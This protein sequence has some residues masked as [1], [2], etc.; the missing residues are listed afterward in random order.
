M[1]AI[2]RAI[3]IV[4]LAL[5]LLAPLGAAA[6]TEIFDQGSQPVSVVLVPAGFET[7]GDAASD[8]VSVVL[9]PSGFETNGDAVSDPVSVVL[10][11]SGF[12][13]N[14]EAVSDPV[15][16]VLTPT[17][18]ETNGEAMSEP[19][20][21]LLTDGSVTFTLTMQFSPVGSGSLCFSPYH[22]GTYSYGEEVRVDAVPWP[23]YTFSH[24]SGDATGTENPFWVIVNSDLA[25]TANFTVETSPPSSSI[26]A[27]VAG[28]VVSGSNLA[29]TGTATDGDMSQAGVLKVEVS[30]NGGITWCKASDTSG[31]TWAS[32]RYDWAIG[33][34]NKRTLISRATD[35]AGNVETP[36]EG[37]SVTVAATGTPE[38]QHYNWN[39]VLSNGCAGCHACPNKFLPTDFGQKNAFCYSCHNAAGV[40]HDKGLYSGNHSVMVNATTGGSRMPTY[41]NISASER[42]NQ[43]FANLNDG[44]VVCITCHNAMGKSE[45]MGRTWEY[46]TTSDRFKYK[47]TNGGWAGYKSLVPKVYRDA[48]LHTAPTY[49]KTRNDYLVAPAEYTFNE[50]SGTV[51][52][53]TQQASSAYVYVSLDYPY[54]R[55][56]NADNTLCA[57]CH[58]QATHKGENCLTCHTAHGTT[59]TAGIRQSIRTAD[60]LEQPVVFNCLTGAGSFADGDATHNGICEVCHIQTKYYRRDGAGFANHS[61]GVNYDRTNCTTCHTH[62]S[63]FAR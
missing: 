31:G 48:S 6:D 29:I 35:F 37:I 5:L 16:V 22:G 33:S 17:G 4:L 41:G 24:W 26:T 20:S 63:G 61:G 14:G 11:P 38:L 10:T 43:L 30:T 18:F 56:S 52:F 42:S 49:S 25:L 8:P 7:N 40:S 12:E 47:M 53:K 13:T 32:W 27:P 45:D 51:T 44:R 21:V 54:L 9:T 46:T 55:A 19:V 60:M 36:G 2:P 28:S 3:T 39:A 59:N 34:V 58:T 50:Y 23:G 1:F 57:D 62:G 15:S